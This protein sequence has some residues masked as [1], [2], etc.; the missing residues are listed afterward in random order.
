MDFLTIQLPENLSESEK[1]KIAEVIKR[2]E[3]LNKKQA[4]KY[5]YI[6]YF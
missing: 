6:F 2:D 5:L 4:E 1:A 3:L